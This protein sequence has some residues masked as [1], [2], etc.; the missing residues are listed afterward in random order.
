M[1]VTQQR[2]P[3]AGLAWADAY[4]AARDRP[5]PLP[6]ETC[7]PEDSQGRTLAEPVLAVA[8][9]PA[10]DAAAMDGYAVAGAG[11][12]RVAGL[13]L[14]GAPEAGL[15]AAGRAAEIATGAPVPANTE[16]V[17]P[18]EDCHVD[19]SLLHGARGPRTHI[20]RA[21]DDVR[22]GTLIVPAGRVMTATRIAAVV[23]A[24]VERIRVHRRPEVTLL[25][26]GDEVVLTGRPGPGQVRDS[27]TGIVDAVTM[28]AGGT[29]HTARLV[30]DHPADLGEALDRAATEV[31][32]V[33]GSSSAGAADHLHALL[34]ERGAEWH[35]RGVASRPG[36]PQALASL[37]GGRWVVSLPG[38]PYA[39]MVSI[40]TLLEPLLRT[41]A[42]R[43]PATLPRM[44]VT[45]TARLMAGGV[46]IA[47]QRDGVLLPPG[48]SAGLTSVA[49]A[50]SLAVL[51]DDWASGDPAWQL[52]VP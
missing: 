38:N 30:G 32:V 47:P 51:P 33:S 25:V 2:P 50:D 9:V 44:P 37:P 46:R 34:G 18:Y 52:T 45:G 35:V 28:R 4:A 49:D 29:L 22:P 6:A 10:F 1:P 3:V 17:L 8:P 43:P 11:P 20:R 36:H 41:L 40:L 42:G 39:G 14:A 15:I 26:T 19:G 7:A 13:I 31:V 12:W 27:F 5:T 21:G 48:G 24:G 23:Q 16:A